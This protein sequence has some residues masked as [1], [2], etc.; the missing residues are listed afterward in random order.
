MIK[1]IIREVPPEQCD[2]NFYFDDDGLT[3]SG[4]NYCYNLFIV[5][6]DGWGRKS[7]FNMSEYQKVVEQAEGISEGFYDVT[8]QSQSWNNYST[9]K[10]VMKDW[11][12]D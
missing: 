4:G 12:I 3:S 7:G 1:N 11:C 6:N 2:F 9:Y 8:H 5:S 10:E